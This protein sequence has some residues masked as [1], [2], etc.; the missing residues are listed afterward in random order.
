MAQGRARW[1]RLC[2]RSVAAAASSPAVSQATRQHAAAA[3][4]PGRCKL[5]TGQT[6]IDRERA[7]VQGDGEGESHWR[8]AAFP[9][10]EA[11][12]AVEEVSAGVLHKTGRMGRV[13]HSSSRRGE[14]KTARG[15]HRGS[16]DSV[17]AAAA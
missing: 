7:E 17:V 12:A 15:P 14:E 1:W 13:R 16:G 3:Q 8:A 11:A 6:Q 10:A 5:L 4:A 2:T 9:A